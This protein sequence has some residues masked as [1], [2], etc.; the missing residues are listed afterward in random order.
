[1]TESATQ[2]PGN[3]TNTE[4]VFKEARE[5]AQLIR[6][7]EYSAVEV[8]EAHLAQIEKY[9]GEIN[10]V[11]TLDVGGAI[12]QA[13]AA[14]AALSR[15]EVWGPLH[16]VPMTIKDSYET[17][18]MR[19]TF[20]IPATAN[21][22][23]S[24]DATVVTKLRQAGA[25]IFGKTNV[26]INCYDWQCQHPNFG[27]TNNPWNL[28]CTPGGSSGGAGA[29]L[30]AGFTPLEVGS[31]VGG[32]IRV[33]AH[34]CGVFG[35]RPTEGSVSGAGHIRMAGYPRS[36]RNL[37]AYGPMARSIADL[38]LVLPL[39]LGSDLQQW[40]IPPMPWSNDNQVESLRGLKV[41]WTEELGNVPVCD[42]TKNCLQNLVSKLSDAGCE[43]AAVTPT[44]FN[45]TEALQVWGHIQGFEAIPLLPKL[46]RVT[47]LR[48]FLPHLYWRHFF[49]ASPISSSLASGM[50]M[51]AHGY[52]EALTKRDKLIAAMEKF[53]C[54]W[55]IWLCPVAPTPAFTHRRRG[56]P[57][58][59]NGQKIS[60]SLAM[61]MYNNTTAV[62]G[63]PIVTLPMG[64]SRSGLPIGVQVHGKRWSDA[65]LLDI[66]QLITP[67]LRWI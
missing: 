40:E 10:A 59:V 45:F 66:A 6:N 37:L 17:Q 44:E 35:I 46:I 38:K 65:R 49:D 11:V 50:E 19:T 8:L 32:S 52:F 62:A 9:N 15:G 30:A 25:I 4:L 1:M 2:P 12:A 18:G 5:I 39:L 54:E 26:P 57:I 41:A 64:K 56:T 3:N 48:R 67:L 61:S 34:F 47:P 27:R 22:I 42:D 43:V 29:A 53:L 20:G 60:Y 33:P 13:K 28:N 16:G 21:Y 23:P 14:D 55:D 58:E 51:D 63:N 24:Q 7:R 31:D 36:M